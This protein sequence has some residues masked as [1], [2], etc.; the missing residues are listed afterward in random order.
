MVELGSRR[1]NRKGA[2]RKLSAYGSRAPQ[3]YPKHRYFEDFAIENR[4]KVARQFRRRAELDNLQV[5]RR[6]KPKDGLNQ[7]GMR[8]GIVYCGH[9]P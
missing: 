8:D 6:V 4:P 2:G 3:I 7:D 9:A 1:T 5:A